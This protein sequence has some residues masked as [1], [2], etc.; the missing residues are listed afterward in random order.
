MQM[1]LIGLVTAMLSM[2]GVSSTAADWTTSRGNAQRTGNVDNQPGPKSA[3]VL[4]FFEAT[5]HF[6]SAPSPGDKA[7]YA[8]ALGTLNSGVMS[9]LSIDPAAAGPKRVL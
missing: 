5:E 2:V 9:A 4:W 6:I 7:I 8:P 3:K 1:R